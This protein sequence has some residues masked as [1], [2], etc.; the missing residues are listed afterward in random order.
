MV[1]LQRRIPYTLYFTQNK[2]TNRFEKQSPPSIS[3]YQSYK[4]IRWKWKWQR[5]IWSI[6]K[7]VTNNT[8][9]SL[10]I[11]HVRLANF[12]QHPYLLPPSREL[13]LKARPWKTTSVAHFT[14]VELSF[15][16]CSANYLV[17]STQAKGRFRK[18][19]LQDWITHRMMH[20]CLRIFHWQL[21]PVAAHR[22]TD[23]KNNILKK[24]Y[25]R[26]MD[27]FH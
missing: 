27:E 15:S 22:F 12:L 5:P 4:L 20:S 7:S 8:K 14:E 19:S 18:Q 13:L 3:K 2:V 1:A 10:L 26:R 24:Y 23:T 11:I 16:A 21:G 6:S 9:A 17:N 25:D